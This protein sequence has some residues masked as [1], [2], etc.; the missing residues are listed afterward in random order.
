MNTLSKEYYRRK[1]KQQLQTKI[2]NIIMI[3]SFLFMLAF[4]IQMVRKANQ[5]QK[6]LNTEIRCKN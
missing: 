3:L 5:L 1:R 2:F 4:S 6:Q